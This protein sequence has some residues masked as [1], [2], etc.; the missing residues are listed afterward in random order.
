MFMDAA[1]RHLATAALL[2]YAWVVNPS[3]Q[4][5]LLSPQVG[6]RERTRASR[7]ERHGWEFVKLRQLGE[8][9][10]G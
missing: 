8:E 7:Q 6:R 4:M 3:S 5:V 1:A 9:C 10:R 2:E